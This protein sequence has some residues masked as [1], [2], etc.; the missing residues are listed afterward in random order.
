MKDFV[1]NILK[2]ILKII[3]LVLWG[4]CRLSELCLQ[5]IGVFLQSIINK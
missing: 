3:L 5:Q 4:A 2:L 1:L